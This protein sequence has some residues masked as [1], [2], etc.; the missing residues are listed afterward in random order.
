MKYLF[1]FFTLFANGLLPALRAQSGGELRFC[2]RSEPKTFNP[3]QVADDSSETVRYLTG[4]VLIRI[5]RRTQNLEPE[6]AR[7]WKILE[8]GRRVRLQLREGVAFSDGTPFSADDVAFTFRALMDPT[9]HSPTG[10][11]FRSGP[12]VVEAKV[13]GPYAISITF[14]AP[15]AGLER[16]FDQVAI[17]SSRSPRKEM[18]VLGPFMVYEH[19]PGSHVLLQRNPQYWKRDESG[20]RLPYLDSIRLEVQQNQE[21]EMLRFLRGRIHLINNMEATLFDRLTAELP[22]A[23]RDA[24]TSLESEQMWFNQVSTAP[25]PDYK[26]SWFQS[27][28][29]R[30]AI[31]EG[32]NR[33]D[34]C[35][36]V[37]LRRASP[38]VGPVSPA[39]QFWFNK[40]LKPH[41]FDAPG[42]LRRL[43]KEG[44]R[45]R[46]GTLLDREGHPVEFSVITNSGNK[47]RERMATMIQQDLKQLGIRLNIVTLDFLSLIERITRTFNYEGCLL[48]LVNVDLDP[49]AQMNVWLSSASNHQWNQ[50]QKSPE[51]NWEAEIDR[52]MQAQ[53]S[54]MDPQKR[55]AS[56]DLVQQLVWEEAPFIY[57]IN[58]NSLA[59]VS[60]L[61]H[62]ATPVAL[63]PQTYW[64]AE[65]LY[66]NPEMARSQ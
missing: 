56:F 49:N 65:W 54:T 64:N 38:A 2:L 5:N 35:R 11:A 9:L 22:L 60:P 10:D 62:N 4:G 12:G 46:Q 58:K 17:L 37:Y 40:T 59:A 34:L 6:L 19:K 27:G 29:F 7:S 1:L 33:E 16:L 30:R 23:A 44:F 53:A 18:A 43:E 61:L 3:L 55:K 50:N 41:T 14:P 51:T 42:A 20:R 31:S 36:V 21:I 8:S 15:V 32:I 25:I 63:R 57:L 52:L 66:L 39:N 24:G 45:L 47:A 26:K 28:N 13:S 48:G